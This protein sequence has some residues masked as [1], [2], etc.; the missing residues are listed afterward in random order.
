MA[1]S[2]HTRVRLGVLALIVVAVVVA[3]L[4]GAFA[5]LGDEDRIEELLADSGAVGPTVYVLS[6]VALQPLSLPGAVLVIPATFVW[7]GWVVFALSWAGGMVASTVGF[8]TARWFGREWVDERLPQRF[9]VWDNRL[10]DHGT[11]NTILLRVVTGYAPPADWV[12]GLSHVRIRQFFVGTAIGL[13][14][15]TAALAFLGDDAARFVGSARGTA[16]T[17]GAALLALAGW[18]WLRR[19]RSAHGT[20]ASGGGRS[21]ARTWDRE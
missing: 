18:T 21:P 3:A 11:R 20:Y 17:A 4:M 1:L 12:L 9:R 16:V 6:F 7:N 19:R 13:L 5:P 8:A 14:P 10:S 15:V 2:A